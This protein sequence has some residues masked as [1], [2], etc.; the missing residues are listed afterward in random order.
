MSRQFTKDPAEVL[1]YVFDWSDWLAVDEIINSFTVTAGNP[2]IVAGSAVQAAGKITFW[3]SGGMLHD[4]YD[5]TCQIRTNAARVASRTMEIV[6]E[7]R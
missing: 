2:G 6:V 5:I 4:H 1:D 3:C 7:T